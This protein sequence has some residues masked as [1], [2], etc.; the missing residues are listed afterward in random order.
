MRPFLSATHT[1]THTHTH[2]QDK[3][4]YLLQCRTGKRT[5][6]AAVRIAVEM[7]NEGAMSKSQAISKVQSRHLDQ[8][9]HP[10]FADEQAYLDRVVGRGLPASPGAA[11]GAHSQKCAV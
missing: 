2:T 9:L 11:V 8:L 7:F 1:H 4:L 6:Q 5:G 10:Q 3:K